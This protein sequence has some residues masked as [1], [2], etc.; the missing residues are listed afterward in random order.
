MRKITRRPIENDLSPKK[1]VPDTSVIIN[2]RLSELVASG[3][4]DG[5]EIIIPEIVMEELQAQAS[6]M[7]ESGFLGLDEIKKLRLSCESHNI[8]FNF[9]GDRASYDDIMLA[10]SGRLDAL[11]QDTA[12]KQEAMLVTSDLPQ[13]LVAEARGIAVKYY[14]SHPER[15]KVRINDFFTPDTMSVHLKEGV[16]P[17]AKRGRPGNVS[18]VRISEEK[19]STEELE[20]IVT[21]IMD[22]AKFEEGSFVEFSDYGAS[23]VQL[24]NIR[25]AITRPP[26]SSALEITAV[27]PITKLTLDDYKLSGKLKERL[28]DKAEGILLAGPPGSGKS[29]FAASLAEFYLK[30]GNVVKTMETPRDLQVSK[31]ITQYAPLEGSFAKTADILLLVRP[32]YTIFDEVR[33]AKDFEIFADMRLAGVGMVGVVHASDPI[34]SVQRFIGKIDFGIIPSVIDTIIYINGGEVKKVYAL[35]FSVKVPTGMFEAD[36]A[37][38]VVEIKDF[39]TGNLEYEIYTYGEQTV[40]IPINKKPATGEQK[41]SANKIR[42]IVSRIDPDAEVEFVSDGRAIVRVENDAIAKLIGKDGRNI[43]KLEKST[44]LRID[45]Q[46]KVKSFGKQAELSIGETGAYIVLSFDHGLTGKNANIYIENDYLFT[47]TVGR[48]GEIKV[49]KNSDLGEALVGAVANRRSVKAFI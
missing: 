8:R 44:G 21:E 22:V 1:V 10:K 40:V 3:K 48:K 33:K 47:A 30:Q 17:H 20:I 29:T 46:P 23:V 7:K 35:T 2:G 31:E 12:R 16:C 13:A 49:T 37:R 15:K 45:V 11:I 25:I 28:A 9:V 39:E 36:L 18:L 6:K 38:P 4:I 27:R 43:K 42:R 41:S 32:D 19:M 34:D 14:E 5:S 26:F 24:R